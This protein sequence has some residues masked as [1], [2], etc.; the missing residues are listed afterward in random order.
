MKG[1]NSFVT[2]LSH[3]ALLFSICKHCRDE[4]RC[5]YYSIVSPLAWYNLLFASQRCIEFRTPKVR[6]MIL[7]SAPNIPIKSLPTLKSGQWIR[8]WKFKFSGEQAK[9]API[10][11][12]TFRQKRMKHFR[13]ATICWEITRRWN[14]LEGELL[15]CFYSSSLVTTP[16]SLFNSIFD[17]FVLLLPLTSTSVLQQMLPSAVATL[18][19]G[20]RFGKLF[21]SELI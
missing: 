12:E 13:N 7:F 20:K 3:W 21:N 16:N 17:L 14:S 10:N 11:H 18:N 2:P 8:Q 15:K 5:L 1:K 9:A 6:E 19:K 4:N